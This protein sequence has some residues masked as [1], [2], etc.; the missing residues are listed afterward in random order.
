VKIKDSVVLVSGGGK[1]LGRVIV[2]TLLEKGANVVAIDIDSSALASIPP[3]ENLKTIEADLLDPVFFDKTL[4]EL[5]SNYKFNVLVNNAGILHNKPLISFGKD[6]FAKLGNDEWDLVLSLNLKIPVFISREIAEHMIKG[7][8]KGVI[9]NISSISA[10]GNVGQS[11]YS[12]SKAGL[13]SFTK[14]ISKELGPWGIRAACVAPGYMDT[15]STH[16]VMNSDYLANIV[17]NV[18]LKRLGKPEDIANGVCFLIE[19]DFF[20]GKIL[21]IDGG[22]TI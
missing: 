3:H 11:A 18:P 17:K 1:G 14:V 4:P 5:L 20:T 8:T 2:E 15:D 16:A 13:E 21:S 9:I 6:G 10:A 7:R 12:A 22:L 19:N